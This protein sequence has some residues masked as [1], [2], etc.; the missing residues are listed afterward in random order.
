[1]GK[2][3]VSALTQIFIFMVTL[4]AEDGEVVVI[5]GEQVLSPDHVMSKYM[6]EIAK[7]PDAGEIADIAPIDDTP[8]CAR[9]VVHAACRGGKLC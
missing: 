8:R 5:G 7:R 4:T 6:T 2:T 3:S 9:T 1:M